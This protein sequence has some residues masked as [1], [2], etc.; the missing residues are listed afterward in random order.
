MQK[1]T[2]VLLAGIL[3]LAAFL[4]LYHL[5]SVPT[6]LIADELDLYNSAYSIATTGH[7]VDGSLQPFLYSRFT[8]NPPVYGFA[9][10]ASTVVLGGNAFALR[11]PA[12]IFGLAAV[13]LLY[14]IA[15]R[16]TGRR[17]VALVAALLMATQPIFIHFSRIAWEPSSELPFLLGGLYA[18]IAALQRSFSVRWLALAVLLLGITSYTY[19]AGWF[20]ALILGGGMIALNFRAIRSL[21]DALKI[22]AASGLW[23]LVSWPALHMVFFDP[24]TAGK[25]VRVATFAHGIT[26]SALHDFATNYA[27]HFRIS[28]LA[29]MGDP[30]PGVTWRYLNGFGAFLWIVIPLAAAG[31]A[32][33]YAY[34]KEQGMRAWVYLWLLAYPLGGALTNDGAPNAPRTLAGAPVFC[35]LAAFGVAFFGD[36]ARGATRR[37]VYA[38]FTLA[39]LASVALFSSFYFTAYVHRNSNA[40]DSGTAALFGTIRAQGAGYQRVCFNVRP[41]SY[42]TDVYAR[43]YLSDSKLQ[44]FFD[45]ASIECSLPG[46]LIAADSQHVPKGA[47]IRA[48]ASVP[49]IDGAQFA[50]LFAISQVSESNRPTLGYGRGGRHSHEPSGAFACAGCA[51]H[52]ACGRQSAHAGRTVRS[53]N[54]Q[55]TGSERHDLE[56]H[57]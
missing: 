54:C 38:A 9:A 17:D 51:A 5:S 4:R 35:L 41:A 33:C 40:W 34:V 22:L 39:C 2:L 7:D 28:Y 53:G 12:V 1:Q 19:M 15:L 8:R 55:R 37:A 14:G 21:R 49:D 29:K 11:L 13:L 27:A 3:C 36:W 26:W 44:T 48:L 30:T 47:G 45:A 46:T 16:L 31:V 23:L 24:L 56:V 10:Y 20:Y 25:T 52:A 57:L 6:E 43:Y 42:E 18:L 32:A 50:K